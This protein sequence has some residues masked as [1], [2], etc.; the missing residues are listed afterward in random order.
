MLRQVATVAMPELNS[1]AILVAVC[2]NDNAKL[3]RCR[4]LEEAAQAVI[5]KLKMLA[6]GATMAT[7][8]LNPLSILEIVVP[9]RHAIPC[10]A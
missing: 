8:K 6:A 4:W 7:P 2:G 5:S 10:L 1:G 3:R 9:D